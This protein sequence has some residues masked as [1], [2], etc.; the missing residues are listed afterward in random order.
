M[1]GR[2]VPT[3]TKMISKEAVSQLPLTVLSLPY[4]RTELEKEL[5]EG[6]EFEG[7]SNAEVAMIRLADDAARGSF[8]AIDMLQDRVIGK[9]KMSMESKTLTMTYE[10]LLDMIAKK[11]EKDSG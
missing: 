10:D 6:E 8:R 1:D 9:P 4:K 2:P 5:G 7:M 11:E 3:Y